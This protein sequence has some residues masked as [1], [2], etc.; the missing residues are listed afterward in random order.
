[1]NRRKQCIQFYHKLLAHLGVQ[2]VYDVISNEFFWPSMLRDIKFALSECIYCAKYKHKNGRLQA[3]MTQDIP[4]RRFERI[5][6]DI[7]GPFQRTRS[8]NQYVLAIVDYFSKYCSLIPLRNIDAKTIA[9]K[10]FNKWIVHFGVPGKIHTD[11][12]T[13]FDSN[14]MHQL[15][16]CLGINKSRTTPYYPQSDGL[17]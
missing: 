3:P 4:T 7:S 13:N 2:K 11:Q 14:L 5:A 16:D 12:G 9:T 6:L 8:N 10:L 17:V 15:C 1:V